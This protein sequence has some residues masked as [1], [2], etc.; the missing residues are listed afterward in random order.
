MCPKAITGSFKRRLTHE[1][2]RSVLHGQRLGQRHPGRW[3]S[4]S[5]RGLQLE[6]SPYF[7]SGQSVLAADNH[8]VSSTGGAIIQG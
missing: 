4:V 7:S 6:Q 8:W 1:S 5:S 3:A 2:V